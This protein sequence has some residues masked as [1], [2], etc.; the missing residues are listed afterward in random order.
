MHSPQGALGMIV[1][2][3]LGVLLSVLFLATQNLI[4]P[5]VAHYCINLVQLVW[6]TRD[7]TFPLG[8][9]LRGAV[10]ATKQSLKVL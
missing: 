8:L 10:F 3:M 9:S 4:A 6:A 1:A 7:K 5:F 2:A